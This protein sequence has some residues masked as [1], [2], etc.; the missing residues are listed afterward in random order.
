ME[1]KV[2]RGEEKARPVKVNEM[3]ALVWTVT[4]DDVAKFADVTG[5]CNPL[6]MDAEYAAQTTFGRRIAHGAF[7]GGLISR[8]IAESLP[9]PGS[10]Y[11]SQFCKF[12]RPVYIGDEIKVV[13]E[14]IE[15]ASYQLRSKTLTVF[16]NKYKL[17]TR[18]ENQ[19]GQLVLDGEAEVLR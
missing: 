14:V 13:V 4:E 15:V 16:S 11:M 2:Y 10:V 6:H 9:G 3:A 19:K 18:V 12:L 17:R 5:D 7:V 8:V 1:S